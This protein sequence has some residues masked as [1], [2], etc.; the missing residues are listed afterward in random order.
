[1]NKRRIIKVVQNRSR[2]ISRSRQERFITTEFVRH[3][4]KHNKKAQ[5][6]GQIHELSIPV[7]PNSK[8][9]RNSHIYQKNPKS[10]YSV[11]LPLRYKQ[12]EKNAPGVVHGVSLTESNAAAS[13]W[14]ESANNAIS[15]ASATRKCLFFDAWS[16]TKK[17][18]CTRLRTSIIGTQ[19]IT[20]E[21]GR[22]YF[23]RV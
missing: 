3:G 6:T 15:E 9:I 1:M 2:C 13:G 8:L 12:R 4:K 14:N 19:S 18:L 22:A 10:K 5:L 7:Q 23:V 11:P 17:L 21:G 20:R 16:H